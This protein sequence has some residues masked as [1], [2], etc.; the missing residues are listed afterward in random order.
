M[1]EATQRSLHAG[2]GTHLARPRAGHRPPLPGLWD[3]TF[4]VAFVEDAVASI[5]KLA[6]DILL[7]WV[8]PADNH[9]RDGTLAAPAPIQ[10]ILDSQLT[11]LYRHLIWDLAAREARKYRPDDPRYQQLHN[12][13]TP[14]Y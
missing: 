14:T 3:G 1:G 9:D 4:A 7:L 10:G 5:H 11:P 8:Q 13:P 2:V 12:Y 6:D